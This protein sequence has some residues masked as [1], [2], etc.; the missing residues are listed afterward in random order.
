MSN[1]SL[2][3]KM[4]NIERRLRGLKARRNVDITQIQVLSE[5]W[6]YSFTLAKRP[7]PGWYA[8]FIVT[9]LCAGD[10]I[11]D[12]GVDGLPINNMKITP[13]VSNSISGDTIT[14]Q[15]RIFNNDTVN[16]YA[17]TPTIRAFALNGLSSSIVRTV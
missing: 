17:M 3:A 10:P 7:D 13:S 1:N 6:P 8:E 9:T 15:V 2:V 12:V 16:G 4:A 14:S 5:A 11:V